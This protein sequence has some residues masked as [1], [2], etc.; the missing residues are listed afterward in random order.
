MKRMMLILVPFAFAGS[1]AAISVQG[2]P[3]APTV[4][5]GVQKFAPVQA[6][7]TQ[8]DDSSG[9]RRGTLEAVNITGG[10]FH[11][12]GQGMTFD[13][14]RVKVFGRDGKPASLSSLRKGAS[15]RFTLDPR[16]RLHR[17]VAVIYLE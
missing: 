11:V 3:P 9:L 16:D 13:P 7:T 2:T 14:K 1:A 4:A 15:V 5:P 8:S 12:Y 10:T 6:P 17:R